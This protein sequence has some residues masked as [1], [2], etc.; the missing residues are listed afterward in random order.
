MRAL[1][2]SSPPS[3]L[4]SEIEPP[5]SSRWIDCFAPAIGNAHG[6]YKDVPRLDVQRVVPLSGCG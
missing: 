4:A 5:S 3:A 1:R 6:V 2:A